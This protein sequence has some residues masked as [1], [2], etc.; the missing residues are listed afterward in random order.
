M[1]KYLTL[2]LMI[3]L[4]GN[5]FSQSKKNDSL[6][7]VL[8]EKVES[9]ENKSLQ[10]Q[11]PDSLVVKNVQQVDVAKGFN[12]E[13]NMPWVVLLTIGIL[14]IIINLIISYYT[15]K[16]SFDIAKLQAENSQTITMTQIKA[17]I[18]IQSIV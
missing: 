17:T 8:I 6:L 5:A 3:C 13:K 12:T 4:I 14:T 15:R 1:K 18:G 16:S 9:L 2:C 10:I 7:N 11:I